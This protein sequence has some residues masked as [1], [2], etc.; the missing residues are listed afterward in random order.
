MQ[1]NVDIHVQ[2]KDYGYMLCNRVVITY[3]EAKRIAKEAWKSL[4]IESSVHNEV[5]RERLKNGYFNGEP[6]IITVMP[7][8]S[9]KGTIML[10]DFGKFPV[11]VKQFMEK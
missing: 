11:K 6:Y 9:M 7:K 5:T 10:E 8:D 2:R 1:K 3:K 4:M